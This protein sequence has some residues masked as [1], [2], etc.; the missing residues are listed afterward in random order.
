MLRYTLTSLAAHKG[1][2]LLTAVAIVLGV[3]VV[4]GTFV[5]T[6][7][8]DAAAKAT[9]TEASPRVDVVV[10][11]ARH[12]EQE[13]FSDITGELFADPMPASVVDRAARVDGVAAAVGVVTGD[14]QLVGRDG[15]VV[16][17][18]APLGR[19]IDPSFAEDLR[20]G[21][22]PTRPGELVVDRR[23]ADDQRLGP[24][25]QVRI[26]VSGGEPRAATVV[27]ILDS[28]EI[29]A[30][31]VL[32]GFDPATATRL[33]APAKGQ[34]SFLEVHGAAGVGEQELRDRVAAA[35][36][37]GYQ[38][39]TETALDAER[40]RNAT[41]S[42][43]GDGTIF[44]I[45]GVVALFV[46]TFLIRN[47]FSIVLASRTRELALLRCVG[48]S[49]GQL[50]R[51]VLLESA[52]LGALAGAAGLLFGIGLA[53][54]LGGLLTS[55]DEAIVD[56]TGTVRVLPRT[57]ALALAA[58]VGTAVASA[59]SPA[60]RATRVAP[61]AALRGEVFAL[62]RRAGRVRTAVGA[63]LA[64]AGVGLVLAGALSNPVESSYL[65]A[66]TIGS[67][68]GVLVLGPVLARSLSRLLGAPVSRLRGV[69]GALARD[70]AAR[71][72]RRTSATVLPL[73]IGL[74]L[75]SFLTTLA[76]GTKAATVGGFDRTF[77]ADYRLRATGAGMHQPL[78]SPRVADRL[79]A[80]PE[81]ATVAAFGSVPATID[82]QEAGVTAVDP[83]RLL[84]VLSPKVTE[85]SLTDLTTGTVAVDRQAAEATDARIGS[86]VT[87]HTPRGTLALT[88]RAVY[89]RSAAYDPSGSQLPVGDYLITP[90]DSRRLAG[91]PALETILASARA[92][93]SPAAA[94]AA[95]AGAIPDHPNVEIASRDELRR[96]AAAQIDPALRVFYGL[97]GIAI[98]V[99]LFGIANTL[100]LSVLERVHELGL[101][102][103]IGAERRQVRSMVRWEAVIVAAIGT[104]LGLAL[105]AFVGWAVSR[106][107]D[108]HPTVPVGQLALAAAAA[109]MVAVLAAVLPAR[110][111]ARVD[112]LRAIATE[113]PWT[114]A[115]SA[116]GLECPAEAWRAWTRCPGGGYVSTPDGGS[117]DSRVRDGPRPTPSP[118]AHARDPARR[119]GG[120]RVRRARGGRHR[121][122]RRGVR[123]G[124]CLR[125][126]GRGGPGRRRRRPRATAQRG[127]RGGPR[128]RQGQ[129]R[130][131]V[132]GDRAHLV[133]R[134]H[135]RDDRHGLRRHHRR[136]DAGAEPGLRR[137]LRRGEH[138][139]PVPAR[140]RGPPRQRR[141]VQ[142]GPWLQGRARHEEGAARR[143]RR[144][145]Q[146][147]HH[148]GRRV[149]RLGVLPVHLQDSP[150][151]RRHRD[152]L[153]L[154]AGRPVRVA[155][156]ARFHPYPRGRALAGAVPHLPGRL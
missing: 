126:Q 10:R 151:P 139:L 67:A 64:L 46:G 43:S 117:G 49:R 109:T 122:T 106:D 56:V 21:R 61:V 77:H 83:A 26:I 91:T 69:V 72:P 1:R 95:I 141:V 94:R 30:A 4:A 55:A 140:R 92:G 47:T 70:N 12:G 15:H 129:G 103:A 58:G 133:P 34:V 2:L 101:L 114:R 84:Q 11:T 127:A 146:R 8:A 120:R 105:G 119:H 142:R 148:L 40:A 143:R 14:A 38:A 65:V 73:V 85:G 36:G 41:P 80:L 22:L 150:L 33:L 68:L 125:C 5:L 71:S 107:L 128:Q 134:D 112:P 110:R 108:V 31:V 123:A 60:R 156:L 6:D 81:L 86:Q 23:T 7:S 136:A 17:V 62:D 59:W 93:V 118:P 124:G 66:G 32:V 37:P 138:R 18:R 135:R 42:E 35:L 116:A 53:W 155:V 25:D 48:A 102:R 75:V 99:G 144:H 130:A 131:E 50:R 24:G 104:A 100:G 88:V 3:G 149:P 63:L 82:G 137:R 19:S 111:A 113:L 76:A 145:P 45:A 79:A 39:F 52:L 44:L 97:L 121:V 152:G 16:G 20:A 154:D 115:A 13:V 27:G 51:S 54:A 29:P 74:A 57:V 28:A 78:M 98:V 147:V 153:P 96:Q 132:P 87:V 89:D 90:A 9:F